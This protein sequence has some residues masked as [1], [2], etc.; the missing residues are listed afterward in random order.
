[1]KITLIMNLTNDCKDGVLI[2]NL[3]EC[4]FGYLKFG[5]RF[6]L[7]LKFFKGNLDK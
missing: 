1:M 4:I 2:P 3:T 6:S 7:F 5:I